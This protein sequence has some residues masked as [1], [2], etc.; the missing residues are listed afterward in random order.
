MNEKLFSTGRNKDSSGT[1][2]QNDKK[3]K[4]ACSDVDPLQP[5]ILKGVI[6]G[7]MTD[8]LHVV[9]I[10]GSRRGYSGAPVFN[11]VGKLGG[12]LLEGSPLFPRRECAGS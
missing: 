6:E 12:I 4:N 8:C 1:R 5:T 3:S 10:P 9:G 2:K 7:H 11:D